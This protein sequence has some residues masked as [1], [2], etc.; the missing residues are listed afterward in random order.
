MLRLSSIPLAF[1]L[2]VGLAHA[3]CTREPAP[4]IPDGKSSTVEVM[5][6]AQVSVKSYNA[7]GEAFLAC[8][9]KDID[10]PEIEAEQ[11]AKLTA[12]Y[13]VAVDEMQAVG[14][15]WNAAVTAFKSK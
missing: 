13:N 5:K 12:E 3:A 4:S 6:A 9:Q 15:Q 10:V 2:S 8:M 1:A 11:K 14:A 7:S